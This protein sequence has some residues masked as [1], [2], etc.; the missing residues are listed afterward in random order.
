MGFEYVVDRESKFGTIVFDNI[1]VDEL[2]QP[3]HEDIDGRVDTIGLVNKYRLV[4]VRRTATIVFRLKSFL[5]EN[6]YGNNWEILIPEN[7]KHSVQNNNRLLRPNKLLSLNEAVFL[8]LGLDATSL[9]LP[10]FQNMKLANCKKTQDS[11]KTI[12]DI[13]C[14][15]IEYQELIRNNFNLNNEK[16][17]SDDLIEFAVDEGFF[18]IDTIHLLNPPDPDNNKRKKST[19]ETQALITKIARK[20]IKDHPEIQKQI[21]ASDINKILKE[22]H[23]INHLK[24]STVER[25]YL[26]NFKKLKEI[27]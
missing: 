17:L 24:D 15:T 8:L 23:N 20:L 13:L 11:I 19:Q 16:I 22:E 10:P 5:D 27:P 4:D 18:N 6:G 21:L 2:P 9:V 3:R 7:S 12:R 26:N 14:S 1:N 25:Q